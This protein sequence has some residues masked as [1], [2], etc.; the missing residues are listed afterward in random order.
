MC[1]MSPRVLK[2]KL[3][4]MYDLSRQFNFRK[5]MLN[6]NIERGVL[7]WIIGEGQQT[8]Q[9]LFEYWCISFKKVARVVSNLGQFIT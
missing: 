9:T 6:Y 8:R 7:N 5:P 4:W 1:N 2:D 3:S